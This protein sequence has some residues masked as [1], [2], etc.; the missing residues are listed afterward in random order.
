MEV[1]GLMDVIAENILLIIEYGNIK[2]LP[3]SYIFPPTKIVSDIIYQP[4][5]KKIA[6]KYCPIVKIPSHL[7]FLYLLA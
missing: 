3:Q 1:S 4:A 5:P 6:L 7:E 2:A